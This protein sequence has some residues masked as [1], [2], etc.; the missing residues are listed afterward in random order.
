MVHLGNQQKGEYSTY[1]N[2][3]T[4]THRIVNY[5]WLK[6]GLIGETSLFFGKYIHA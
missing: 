5:D 1:A 4:D 2:S 6:Q 3:Y